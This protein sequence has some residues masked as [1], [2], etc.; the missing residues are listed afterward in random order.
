[1]AARKLLVG[2]RS[3]ARHWAWHCIGVAA[4]VGWL[5][6]CHV[7]IGAYVACCV[8]PGLALTLIRSFAEHRV[9]GV[10]DHRTAIVEAELPFALLFLNNNLHFVHHAHP[11][12]PWYEIPRIYHQRR[13]A[14]LRENG[15]LFFRG[16]R[17]LFRRYSVRP[18]RECVTDGRG[19]A[20]DRF[21]L[22]AIHGRI[23]L[24]MFFTIP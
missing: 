18:G 3:Y 7:P 15:G 16:Y 1:M 12:A 6:A 8:Y 5:R 9:A 13:E 20:R 21:G 10:L 4:V 22:D 24:G 11:D 2:D 14:I 17:A 23:S 19:E